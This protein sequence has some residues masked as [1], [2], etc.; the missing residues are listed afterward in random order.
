[1]ETQPKKRVLV[2][3]NRTAATHRLLEE[4]SRRRASGP[5]GVRAADPG[6]HRPQEG[7]L[8]ARTAYRC[9]RGLPAAQWRALST[10]PTRSPQSRTRSATGTSTRSSLDAFQEDLDGCDG[11]RS[12]VEGLGLPVTAVQPRQT[13]E[14]G[15]AQWAAPRGGMIGGGFG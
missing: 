12:Q 10:T 7:R 3:A 1:M 9:S 5:C 6:R 14:E 15:V 4:V 2:V 13:T 8:D 11:T